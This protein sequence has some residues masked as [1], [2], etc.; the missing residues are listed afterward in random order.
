MTANRPNPNRMSWRSIRQLAGQATV[1]LS[2]ILV[3]LTAAAIVNAA[4]SR[5][6][7]EEAAAEFQQIVEKNFDAWDHDHD[8][9]IGPKDINR[10]IASPHIA[11]SSA[12]AVV[13]VRRR[14][15]TSQGDGKPTAFTKDQL[16]EL[17]GDRK[18]MSSFISL[19]K[20]ID[21]I[22]REVFVPTDPNLEGF[23]QGHEGDCYLLSVAGAFLERNPKALRAMFQE[24]GIRGVE[25]KFGNGRKVVVPPLTDSEVVLGAEVDAQH[26]V[27]L[28]VL[29]KAWAA[30]NE[31]DQEKR[32]G[33][34]V[35]ADAE[36]TNDII[37]H[38]GNP[39]RVIAAFTGHKVEGFK[40]YKSQTDLG[41]DRAA[42]FLKTMTDSKFL[43]S[44][45]TAAKGK[46]AAGLVLPPGMGSHH[47]Y[48]L[49]G[50]DS[51]NRTA[52]VFNPWGNTYKPKGP[53]GLEFGYPTEHGV[54]EVPVKELVHIFSGSSHETNKPIPPT[55]SQ[56]KPAG[57]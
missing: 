45:T 51:A 56:P 13:L 22:F 28:S 18:A 49:L 41:E 9:S 54:F 50:Y 1:V 32:T 43:V 10:L 14:F 48:A 47:A 39:G 8:A 42:D 37:G 12:A 17:A 44:L 40:W 38:G 4:D 21:T 34:T 23:H 20:R 53:P 30:I 24:L 57:H 25:V 7:Q 52:K 19:C 6:Q 11:G 33:T 35:E 16:L 29:E 15:S 55:P 26:G 27:W 2:C 5:S 31:E 46:A 36:I 3:F